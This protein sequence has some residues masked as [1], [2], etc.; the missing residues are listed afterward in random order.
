MAAGLLWALA[1]VGIGGLLAAQ[2]PINSLL[3]RTIG[4]SIAAALISFSVG[5]AVAAALFLATRPVPAWSG[6]PFWLYVAGGCLGVPV[7]LAGII[8]PPKLGA[9]TFLAC[10]IFGQLAVGLVLDHL[11]AFQLEQ[12]PISIG[13]LCAVGCILLG[14]ILLKVF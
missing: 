2:G 6:P 8:L 7:V 12:H 3:G 9:T 13:R 11:G 10:L 14:A 5:A 1:G 4:S